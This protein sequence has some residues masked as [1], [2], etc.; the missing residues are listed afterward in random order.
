MAGLR[1]IAT[2]EGGSGPAMPP[3]TAGACDDGGDDDDGD[4]GD[5]S[6]GRIPA[7][8]IMSIN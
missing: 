1:R 8:L 2:V 5:D 6:D 7:L 4:D 3:A